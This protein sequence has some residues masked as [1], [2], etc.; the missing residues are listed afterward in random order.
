M[1]LAFRHGCQNLSICFSSEGR[2][3]THQYV[4]E[5]SK[6]PVVTG[7]SVPPSKDLWRNVVRSSVRLTHKLVFT[8]LFGKS[9]IN[10]LD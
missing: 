6:R 3:S 4:D 1:E 10:E 7:L 9:K 5:H 8:Q 2:P